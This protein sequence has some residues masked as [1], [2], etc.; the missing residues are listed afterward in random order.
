MFDASR[1]VSE[2]TSNELS[3]PLLQ[4]LQRAQDAQHRLRKLIGCRLRCR[5]GV[6]EE[7]LDIDG[8]RCNRARALHGG[9]APM[10]MTVAGAI[11]IQDSILTWNSRPTRRCR[12]HTYQ[13]SAR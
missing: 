3:D 8:R 2:S 4:A 12:L 5:K 6:P 9:V 10:L 11:V 1:V 7:V 13:G